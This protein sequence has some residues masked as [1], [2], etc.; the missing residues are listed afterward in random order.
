MTN[1]IFWKL[2]TET[3][4]K[5][6][7]IGITLGLLGIAVRLNIQLQ[8]QGN[9][10]SI[11]EELDKG[12]LFVGDHQRG[13]EMHVLNAIVG[14]HNR[15]DIYHL[16]TLFP[17]GSLS[18]QYKILDI[19]HNGNLLSVLPRTPDSDAKS[20]IAK[21]IKATTAA[22]VFA[23][24]SRLNTARQKMNEDSLR[25][26]A[27]LLQEGHMVNIYPTGRPRPINTEWKQGVGKIIH[28]VLE[29]NINKIYV[30][31]YILEGDPA[32]TIRDAVH[33]F[34]TN[35]QCDSPR[36]I[37]IQVGKPV[38]I[39]DLRRDTPITTTEAVKNAYLTA[40]PK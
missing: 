8:T 13:I 29:D 40:I 23:N 32:Q 11:L 7:T 25:R 20:T 9:N 19:R 24:N 10:L 21:K 2:A 1:V 31:P 6:N 14:Q 18:R 17:I 35:G 16:A 4:I 30:I 26:A 33:E 39:S 15:K 3:L 27:V 34:S 36:S 22:V 5:T 12:I 37:T 38:P 28:F